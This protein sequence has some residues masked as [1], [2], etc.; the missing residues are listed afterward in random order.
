MRKVKLMFEF[1]FIWSLSRVYV[2]GSLNLHKRLLQIASKITRSL[3]PLRTI[4]CEP[5]KYTYEL[6]IPFNY[7]FVFLILNFEYIE[8]KLFHCAI[9]HF[10]QN[11]VLNIKWIFS[12]KDAIIPFAFGSVW[13]SLFKTSQPSKTNGIT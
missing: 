7:Y 11:T 8:Q 3:S 10:I 12:L 9:W 5:I 1:H 4:E 6:C 2:K 13:I